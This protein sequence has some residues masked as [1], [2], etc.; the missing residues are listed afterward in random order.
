MNAAPE[1]NKVITELLNGTLASVKSVVPVKFDMKKPSLVKKE[2]PLNF[3]VLIGITGEIKGKLVLTGEQS[4][5]GSI[6]E[7]MFG[8]PLDGEMLMSFSGELGN[9]IAGG[10]STN[11]STNG[12]EINITA[13]TILQGST[14]LSGYKHGLKVSL[15][16]ENIGVMNLF[17]LL[18]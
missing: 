17:L 8:M 2:F 18:D 11:I 3:A 13:P 9:M 15:D 7:K 1:R 12:V 16:F 4:I 6:G 5:F 14:I 10:L